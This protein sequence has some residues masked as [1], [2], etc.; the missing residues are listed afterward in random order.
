MLLVSLLVLPCLLAAPQT[1]VVEGGL[2]G[3]LEEEPEISWFSMF[4]QL[5]GVAIRYGRIGLS[6][7]CKRGIICHLQSR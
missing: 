7:N 3:G 4:S 1:E 6:E 5:A 2:E